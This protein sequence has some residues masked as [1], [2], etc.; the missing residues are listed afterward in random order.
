MEAGQKPIDLLAGSGSRGRAI[1]KAVLNDH[2]LDPDDFFGTSRIDYLVEARIDAAVRMRARG[3]SHSRIA[4]MLCRDRS[5]ITYYLNPNGRAVKRNSLR[6]T[7]AVKLLAPDTAKFVLEIANA[8]QI[9]PEMLIAQ[10]ISER[11]SYEIE[12]RARDERAA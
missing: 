7:R 10:W 9:A 2:S 5:T 12:A 3:Y 8:E 4:D 6:Q 11:A 1:I